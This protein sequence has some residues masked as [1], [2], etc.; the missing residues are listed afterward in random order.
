MGVSS[1][2]RVVKRL[3]YLLAFF[4]DKV[5]VAQVKR[6]PGT[7]SLANGLKPCRLS[8]CC[9]APLLS[10][11][12]FLA[13]WLFC[14]DTWLGAQFIQRATTR[15]CAPAPGQT[16]QSLRASNYRCSTIKS[17]LVDRGQGF[18]QGVR[19]SHWSPDHRISSFDQHAYAEYQ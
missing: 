10:L 17:P 16:S 9:N 13:N 3:T 15:Y 14:F 2:T 8:P 18:R 4:K 19:K 1:V 11:W 5:I 12:S 7:N 6:I